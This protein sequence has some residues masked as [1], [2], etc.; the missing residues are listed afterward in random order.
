MLI[1]EQLS[2][3]KYPDLKESMDVIKAWDHTADVD[4]MEA[5]LLI[6]TFNNLASI[7]MAN[8]MAYATNTLS[9]EQYVKALRDATKHMK[10]HFGSLRVRLGDVQKHVR[11]DKVIGVG[12][13]PDVLAANMSK[14]YKK[15][16]LKTFVGESYIILV[17]FDEKGVPRIESINAFGTSNHPDSPHYND[18]MELW[19]KQ[20]TKPMTLN[21]DE[22]NRSAERVYHPQ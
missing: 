8:G 17:D 11:G 15:G 5:A 7:I 16:M 21:K 19:T 9:E 18:Q 20:K 13:A 12:G 2:T 10:K 22:I 6:F 3:I 14:P 4:D 1:I